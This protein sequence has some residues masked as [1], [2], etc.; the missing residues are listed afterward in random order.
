MD[1][2]KLRRRLSG[3]LRQLRSSSAAFLKQ[4]DHPFGLTGGSTDLYLLNLGARVLH[5]VGDNRERLLQCQCVA[6]DALQ[7]LRVHVEQLGQRVFLAA[8]HL[9]EQDRESLQA[10]G[11]FVDGNVKLH[12]GLLD[13]EQLL[14]RLAGEFGEP[15]QLNEAIDQRLDE[16]DRLARRLSSEIAKEVPEKIR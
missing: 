3:G 2:R 7:R 15:L 6:V 16:I 4:R 14:H 10:L 8:L 1:L 13:A 12:A 5:Q 9:I 11:R